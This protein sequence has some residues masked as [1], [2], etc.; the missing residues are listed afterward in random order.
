M[1]QHI[2]DAIQHTAKWKQSLNYLKTYYP[3]IGRLAKNNCFE[4]I[5]GLLYVKANQKHPTR[6]LVIPTKL[7]TPLLTYEHKIQH[8]DHPGANMLIQLLSQKYFWYLMHEDIRYYVQQCDECQAGK[9][10]KRYKRGGLEPLKAHE[11]GEI[12]HMD[13]AGPFFD[14]IKI[15]VMVDNY[16]GATIYFP[17]DSESAEWMVFGLIHWWIPYHGVPKKMVTDRGKGFIAH[18]NRLVYKYLGIEKLFTSSYHPQT[19]AK[20]ERRV[21]ELKKAYRMIN[22]ELDERYTTYDKKNLN[23]QKELA[24]ELIL[25]LPS[26]Q[27]AINQKI[28]TVT[29]VSP[30]MMVYGK[31]LRDIIDFKTARET[32][33]LIEDEN[34]FEDSKLKIL[35]KLQVQLELARQQRDSN[36]EDYVI[37]MKENYDQDKYQDAFQV[38]DKVAYYIGDRSSTNKT[39]QRRFSGPWTITKRISHN[40]V[41][42]L[43]ED[44]TQFACHV[45]MLKRYY[46]HQFVPLLEL[47]KSERAKRK[48]VQIEERQIRK[49][50]NT[51]LGNSR[52]KNLKKKARRSRKKKNNRAQISSSND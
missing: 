1:C 23:L 52:K 40:T 14:R 50:L 16:T 44:G 37:V 17:C 22:I 49:K 36:Y 6:R 45:S 13:G 3:T 46:A 43:N 20:A 39:L 5:D 34:L 25:L 48:R 38:G 24:D 29:Q 32:L 21:Q 35:K 12:V 8:K 27:F 2:H 41:E 4:W 30:H 47:T 11:H 9:G 28:H 7:I 31:N 26:I 19:N 15:G 33:Q 51:P 42:I 10:S 18:A